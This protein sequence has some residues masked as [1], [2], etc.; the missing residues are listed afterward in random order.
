MV[1]SDLELRRVGCHDSQYKAPGNE[2]LALMADVIAR[3]LLLSGRVLYSTI[4]QLP[5]SRVALDIHAEFVIHW[6]RYFVL[7]NTIVPIP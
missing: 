3:S 4:W 7:S 6:P 2:M 5:G 1:C